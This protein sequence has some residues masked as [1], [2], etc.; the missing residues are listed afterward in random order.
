MVSKPVFQVQTSFKPNQQRDGSF[1]IADLRN[2]TEEFLHHLSRFVAAN[3]V[4]FSKEAWL[5]YW[6]STAARSHLRLSP[7]LIRLADR[8]R[9]VEVNR[10]AQAMDDV[11]KTIEKV[12]PTWNKAR[13]TIQMLRARMWAAKLKNRTAGKEWD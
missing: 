4:S 5:H 3:G 8:T 6:T 7:Q 10:F 11:L 12:Q 2:A 13:P 1:S 9:T